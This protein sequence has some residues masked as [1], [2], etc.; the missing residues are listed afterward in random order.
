M[1]YWPVSARWDQGVRVSHDVVSR[2]EV[3]RNSVRQTLPDGSTS[4]RV[5]NGSVTVDETSKVRRSLRLT[6]AN[7]ELVPVVSGDLLAP[8]TTDL[9]V[10]S[11]IRYTEG[12]TEFVPVGVFR[13]TSPSQSAWLGGLQIQADDYA[14]VMIDARFLSPWATPAGT[15][16]VSEITRIALDALPGITIVDLTGSQVVTQAAAWD[17]DRWDTMQKLAAGIGAEVFFDQAGRMLI[18]YVPQV[19][20][21]SSPVWTIDAATSTAVMTDVAL[22]LSTERLYNAVVASS[23]ASGVVA[24]GVAYLTTGDFAWSSTFKRPRFYSSPALTTV[25]Q[26][27]EA[28][29]SILA[30]S[31]VFSRSIAPSHAPNAALDGGDFVRVKLPVDVN[32]RVVSEMRALSR[33]TFS[34]GPGPMTS[35]TRAPS[36]MS[37]AADIGMLS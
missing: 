30:R 13:I 23:S 25:E 34:L 3:W 24:S 15:S 26:C 8:P 17:R 9:K 5:V 4:L 37:V 21:T 6:V 7:P 32:G 2:V 28:A 16:V 1:P 35:D 11:G 18:R 33:F 20:L 10:F 36:D 19:T 12:D 14:K 22:G 29:R 27:F 31:A